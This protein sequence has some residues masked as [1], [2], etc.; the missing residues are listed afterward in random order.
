MVDVNANTAQGTS[1]TSSADQFTYIPVPTVS[2][3]A[4]ARGPATGGTSVTITGSNFITTTGAMTVTFGATG[5]S[6]VACAS[7]TQCVAT[8]PPGSGS[9]D[10]RVANAFGSS[11]AVP[12]DL[13]TYV[14]ATTATWTEL[15]PASRP[16][17]VSGSAMAYDRFTVG[18]SCS[19]GGPL[20]EAISM[21]PGPG[22]V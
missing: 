6:T 5:A 11:A 1:P 13:F 3:I 18:L 20:V 14:A 15:S 7:A 21:R 2:G 10:V 22:T 8:S 17:W 9:I 16:S 19:A 4:P 12:A